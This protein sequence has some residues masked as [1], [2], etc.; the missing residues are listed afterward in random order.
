MGCIL[1][2][3]RPCGWP[4]NDS[5]NRNGQMAIV[6]LMTCCD[7]FSFGLRHAV[8]D[9]P[10][11]EIGLGDEGHV[12]YT[13]ART[14][15]ISQH[16]SEWLQQKKNP[17]STASSS[18]DGEDK[19]KKS[20]LQVVNLGAGADTRV[21]WLEALRLAS[22][23]LEIDLS[24]V[25]EWKEGILES[26]QAKGELPNPCVLE[27]QWPWTWPRNRFKTCC[28]IATTLT[29]ATTFRLVGSW[30]VWSCI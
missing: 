17:S 24:P 20:E 22:L 30:R 3:R 21:Y 1:P 28:R 9:P 12:L 2:P 27:R 23:Y 5:W 8:F 4:S 11:S 25:L 6:S 18:T 26:L 10:G 7:C 19:H 13:A 29:G 16:V 14:H 15:L